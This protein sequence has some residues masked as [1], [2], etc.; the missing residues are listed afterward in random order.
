MGG[1]LANKNAI[2]TGGGSGIGFEIARLFG[3]EG[4]RVSILDHDGA[5]S[6]KAEAELRGEESMPRPSAST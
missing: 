5:R 4:A 3:C 2:I 6:E 1:R